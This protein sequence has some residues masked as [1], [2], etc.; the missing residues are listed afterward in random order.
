MQQTFHGSCHCRAI[1]FEADIDMSRGTSKCNCTFC[2]KQ[3]NW[4]IV[5]LKPEAFRLTAGAELL[6]D[7]FRTGD[8]FEVHHRF[9]LKCGTATHGHGFIAQMG[10]DY[11]SIRVAA[12]DDL[13]IDA[14][15]SAPIALADGL[16]D[17]WWNSPAEVRHL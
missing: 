16:H 13:P 3:R 8:G 7:Y 6:G 1:S 2:W 5:G 15:M 9:C 17:N 11:V 4:N 14:L 12:L 10:G